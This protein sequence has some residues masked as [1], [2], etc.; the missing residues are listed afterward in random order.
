MRVDPEMMDLVHPQ[1]EGR[2]NY[3]AEV[4]HIDRL[5]FSIVEQ[6]KAT[7][8]LANTVVVV[9]GDHG[10]VSIICVHMSFR[11]RSFSFAAKN[12]GDHGLSGKGIPWQASVS[13]PLLI[14]GPRIPPDQVYGGPVTT[15]D[16]GGTFLDLAGVK[17]TAFA[18]GMTTT[19]LI[20]QMTGMNGDFPL[21]EHVSSGY[22]NWR[23]VVKELPTLSD[24]GDQFVT[25]YKLICCK[26]RACKGAPPSTPRFQKPWQLLLYDVIADPMHDVSLT[27]SR[28]DV[29]E[30]LRVLL[31]GGYCR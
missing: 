21:R 16:L 1:K 29:V 24:N 6:L 22:D 8:E 7:G 27:D 25:S 11:L 31:P 18:R 19:S 13:V 30:Q 12:L 15:L 2:C 10:E 5:M 23:V 26:D 9:A 20:T 14:S 17:P 3:G 28:P 4:E